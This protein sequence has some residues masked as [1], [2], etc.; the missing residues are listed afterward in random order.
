M[1]T[2][3]AEGEGTRVGD[4]VHY[5][6]PLGLARAIA[7]ALIVRKDVERIIDFRREKIAQMFSPAPPLTR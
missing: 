7:H 1:H 2:F 3:R 5:E 6:L 4:V